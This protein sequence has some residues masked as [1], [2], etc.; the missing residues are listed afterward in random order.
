MA[1]RMRLQR[2][3][4]KGRPFYHIVVADGRAPRDGRFIEKIGTYNPIADPAQVVL[5]MDKALQWLQNGAQPSDTVRSLL[6]REGVMMK[7]HL[8]KGV[9]KGALTLEQAEAKFD[10]WM[11]EK[12]NK[13]RS[14]LSEK[15]Q[16]A[17]DL[18]KSLVAAEVKKNEERAQAISR[19]RA[20]AAAAAL[21]QPEGEVAESTETPAE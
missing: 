20:E 3:G 6:S 17:R 19:K 13:L 8:L 2:F 12:Q 21:P 1:V 14:K 5:S 4:K 16:K 11:A 9:T 7:H 15:D 18:K 10:A